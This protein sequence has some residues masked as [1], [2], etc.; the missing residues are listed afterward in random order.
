[1]LR[2]KPKFNDDNG[3]PGPG[4]YTEKKSE[5]SKSGGWK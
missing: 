1:M 3:V 2:G 5:V 4:A